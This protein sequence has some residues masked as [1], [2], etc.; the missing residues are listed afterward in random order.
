MS[1]PTRGGKEYDRAAFAAYLQALLDAHNES[2]REASLAAGLDHGSLSRFVSKHQRPTRESCIAIADHFGLN[3]N[4]VLTRAGYQPM[5]FFDKSLVDP[6]ALPPD[7]SELA[8]YLRR[9][10]PPSRRR[11]LCHSIRELLDLAGLADSHR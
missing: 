4:E 9:V 5:H 1:R 2:M 11:Q 7:V 3:P 8:R 6:D 10:H